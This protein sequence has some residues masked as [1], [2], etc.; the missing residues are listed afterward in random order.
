MKGEW[1]GVGG[2]ELYQQHAELHNGAHTL[3]LQ[4]GACSPYPSLPFLPTRQPL[5]NLLPCLLFCLAFLELALK[6][7]HAL[8]CSS[9][10]QAV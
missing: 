10:L 1:K 2:G 7:V 3:L 4:R 8:V 5:L 6:L 9:E